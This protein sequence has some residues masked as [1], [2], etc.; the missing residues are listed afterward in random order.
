MIPHPVPVIPPNAAAAPSDARRSR[1]NQA[2]AV[3]APGPRHL[4]ETTARPF[5]PH[6]RHR[7]RSLRSRTFAAGL[8]PTLSRASG[9]SSA[10]RLRAR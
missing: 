5:L 10:T 1:R 9:V 7:S 4:I 2:S 6:P 8:N 3:Y